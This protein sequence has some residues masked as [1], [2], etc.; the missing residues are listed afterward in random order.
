M[1]KLNSFLGWQL[2]SIPSPNSIRNWAQK[3]GYYIY[4]D[5]DIN[6]F[7]EGYAAIVDESMMVGSE[8]LLL[9]LG[10]SSVKT[11]EEALSD[12]DVRVLNMRVQTSWNSTGIGRV[13]EE[14]EK[15]MTGSPAYVVSD[16][17]STISKAVRDKGYIHIRDV[18]HT[19]GLFIQQVYEK[20]E[21]FRQF[22]KEVSGVKF[23][24]VM[25]PSAYLLPPKQRTIA[26]FMNLSGTVKW[27]AT[28]LKS[29]NRLSPEEQVIFS[30]IP[31][32]RQ[33]ILEME[34]VFT[35]VN[36]L[37]QR[38]K[39]SGIS[40]TTA[41][42][43]TG[44][45]ELLQASQYQRVVTV[46]G[47]IATYIQKENGKKSIPEEKWHIS[48]DVIESLFGSYKARKS[49]NAMNGVTKQI[50][51]LPLLTRINA[52]KG[53]TSGWF[54]TCLEYVFLKDLDEWKDEHLSENRTVKRRKLLCT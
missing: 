38:L 42:E 10:V 5:T 19:F 53:L 25:R 41:E 50:F 3:S 8:K 52:K 37:L 40:T 34:E 39:K 29:F 44:D 22:M 20:E 12:E 47:L 7:P 18:G 28:M 13:F 14:V 48:S 49:P 16:N 24:E 23:R 26:R 36:S 30:F 43:C 46:G 31:Q 32:H 45:I 2:E 17:A 11:K 54:K 9:T 4:E 33:L 15:K 6:D 35:S 51:I 27:A 1:E 21:D